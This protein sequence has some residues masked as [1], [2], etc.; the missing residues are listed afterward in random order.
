MII[1][2][3]ENTLAGWMTNAYSLDVCDDLQGFFEIAFVPV[4]LLSVGVVAG[5]VLLGGAIPTRGTNLLF[6][7]FPGMKLKILF[8]ILLWDCITFGERNAPT[9]PPTP[10]N[11]Y[12]EL[13]HNYELSQNANKLLNPQLLIRLPFKRSCPRCWTLNTTWW[14]AS[15]MLPPLAARTAWTTVGIRFENACFVM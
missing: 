6:K 10:P 12:T 1:L 8:P 2:R 13:E 7:F 3:N 4:P 9:D 5:V 14:R 11:G 15:A